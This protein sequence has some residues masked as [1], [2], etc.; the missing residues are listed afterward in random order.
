MR[1]RMAVLAFLAL[2]VSIP[3]ARADDRVIPRPE[4]FGN[5]PIE[6]TAD[7]LSADSVKQ[8]V[9]FEGNV[10]AKQGDVT[11][12]ADRLFAEYSRG[13]GA[14]EKIIAEGNVRVNQ[15]DRE[16]RAARAVF[17][18]L[19][20]RIVLSG[21]ADL[22]Q[23]GNTLKGETVTIYLRENRSVITGGEGGRVKAVIQPK[24]LP[25]TREKKGR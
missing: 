18:N 10:I 17:Y 15:Q 13:A 14:I 11:L 8:S 12:Y 4:D 19:E 5:R 25:E 21:G 23:G 6:I 16:A 24:G 7:R 9:S 2:A 20:Q 1:K 3:G 22:V